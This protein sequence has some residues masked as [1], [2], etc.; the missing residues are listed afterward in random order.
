MGAAMASAS[1]HGDGHTKTSE[2]TVEL[3][4]GDGPITI[5]LGGD[6]PDHAPG[7]ALHD[8]DWCKSFGVTTVPSPGS[9]AGRADLSIGAGLKFSGNTDGRCLVQAASY[10][11]RA[12]LCRGLKPLN[13]TPTARPCAVQM[14]ER[15]Q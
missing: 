5:D 8:C 3:C 9:F 11:S 2:I 4:G 10:L 7:M 14:T 15:K 1:S 12:P 6:A 13:P